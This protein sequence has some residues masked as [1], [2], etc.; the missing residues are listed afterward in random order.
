MNYPI[1]F[2]TKKHNT[3]NGKSRNLQE[4]SE[5]IGVVF[6]DP[7]LLRT[8]LTH[9]SYI[10]EHLG[11]DIEHN[12]R[13]EFL[14][15]AVLEFVVTDYLFQTYN[16]PEGELTSLRATA[17]C[18]KTLAEVSRTL[19]LGEYLLLSRGEEKENGRTRQYL[20]ANVC[21]ALIGALY[22]DQGIEVVRDFVNKHITVLFEN[23]IENKL[24]VDPKSKFQE[25]SQN[26][27]GRT[28]YYKDLDAKGPDHEKIFTAG[29][30][31]G[32]ELIAKGDGNSK[33]EAQRQAARNA[34]KK[35]GWL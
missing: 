21:E 19:G 31:L 14:G 2:M 32:K 5:K 17:V 33:Q 4:L 20:L 25:I 3:E 22:L 16:K 30:F 6:R 9:R 28:P 15:D 13:L 24:Y 7:T 34:L 26:K 29:A 10:N 11:E 35:K 1:R 12:E 8:A 18:G 23:I 27:A